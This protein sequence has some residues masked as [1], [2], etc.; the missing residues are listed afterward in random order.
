MRLLVVDPKEIL[1]EGLACILEQHPDFE[2]LGKAA[3]GREAVAM[4]GQLK[5]DVVIMELSV[6]ELNGIDATRRILAEVPGTQV[7]ALSDRAD[8]SAV[9]EM[10][11]AGAKGYL[12]K[13]ADPKELAR[14]V[15]TVGEGKVY[16]HPDVAPAVVKRSNGDAAPSE[17]VFD[18]LTPRE[19]EV[20]QLVAEGRSS[21]EIA[22]RLKISVST[23]DSHRHH[24]M[25]KLG[26]S[27][28]ADLV[29]IAIRA[30]LTT[31]EL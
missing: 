5:P 19:R 4:A 17:P 8:E 27:S 26:V 2:V 11:A 20:L 12:V 16:L 21:K 22:A 9:S 28:V 1:A 14:A 31:L 23:V 29:K 13:G 24:V 15:R 25:K 6:P 7:L 10:L 18:N 3:D 30:G